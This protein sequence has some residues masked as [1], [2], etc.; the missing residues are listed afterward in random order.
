MHPCA[1]AY[2]IVCRLAIGYIRPP[3][4]Y[5]PFGCRS[6]PG[7][8]RSGTVMVSSCHLVIL[9]GSN[10]FL[11]YSDSRISPFLRSRHLAIYMA[12]P[13][14]H[15]SSFVCEFQSN[16]TLF[17]SPARIYIQLHFYFRSISLRYRESSSTEARNIPAEASICMRP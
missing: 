10:G 17:G 5:L 15:S 1:L 7:I 9:T 13:P 16:C 2:I 14:Y 4:P 3:L 12:C 6:G 11:W 8:H